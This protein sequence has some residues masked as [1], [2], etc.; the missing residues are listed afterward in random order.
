MNQVGIIFSQQLLDNRNETTAAGY[1][2][3][4]YHKVLAKH[5]KTLINYSIK[6][7]RWPEDELHRTD[8]LKQENVSVLLVPAMRVCSDKSF[9]ELKRRA[10]E[11][12][13]VFATWDSFYY[14]S[15]EGNPARVMDERF[16]Q[17]FNLDGNPVI[18]RHCFLEDGKIQFK[19]TR[20]SWLTHKFSDHHSYSG[21]KN[22]FLAISGQSSTYFQHGEFTGTEVRSVNSGDDNTELQGKSLPAFMI[23]E[24]PSGGMLIYACF[25]LS[26]LNNFGQVLENIY[27]YESKLA[28]DAAQ[29]NTQQREIKRLRT[30]VIIL[31]AIVFLLLAREMVG[32]S[33][34]AYLGGALAGTVIGI[35]GNKV[36]KGLDRWRSS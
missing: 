15:T 1:K 32:D 5:E 23:R 33:W 25:R 17:L 4:Q 28:F 27:R 11:G 16:T 13:I 36:T 18:N 29:T 7:I 30:A 3:S 31:T 19:N 21:R 20:F 14:K 34:I 2:Y 26:N 12:W 24:Y 8:L 22:S 6:H 10:E 9:I 35:I